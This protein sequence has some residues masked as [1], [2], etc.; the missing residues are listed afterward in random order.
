MRSYILSVIGAAVLAFFSETLAPEGRRA[1]IKAVTG[2]IVVA[3]ILAPAA[4][5]LKADM[6]PSFPDGD[7]WVGQLERESSDLAADAVS[8][9]LERRVAED[10]AKRMADEFGIDAEAVSVRV[11]RASDGSIERVERITV[12]AAAPLNESAVK[13]RFREIYGLYENEVIF[14]DSRASGSKA[15]ASE[16][17]SGKI[18]AK[19]E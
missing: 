7:V 16:S 13:K 3:A 2:I 12:S 9:E 18:S 6:L 4:K 14:I 15:G 19:P 11:R 1:Y 10:A 5:L 17:D 8:H